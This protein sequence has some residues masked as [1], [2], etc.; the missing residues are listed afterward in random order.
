MY[1]NS[2]DGGASRR[3]LAVILAGVMA[4]ALA[5][6]AEAR[7][8]GK[9]SFGSR[10]SRTFEAPP[11]TRTAPA[12]A[13][14]MQRSQTTPSQAQ[15][16]PTAAA[17]QAAQPA[18]SRFGGGFFAGLLGAGLLGA[19]FGAG[20]FGGLGSLAS[21]V[22]FVLQLGLIGGLAYLA[23]QFFRRRQQPAMAGAGANGP[24]QRTALGGLAAQNGATHSGAGASALGGAATA[25]SAHRQA[26][27]VEIEPDDYAA[28]ERSLH[29]I[30]MAYGREDVAALWSLATPEMAGYLQEELNENARR[31]VLNTISGVRLV[32]GDLAEAWRE[33]TTDYAT[34]AMRFELAEQMVDRATRQPAASDIGKPEPVTEV[35]TFRREAGGDW[36]LSAIQQVA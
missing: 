33:G 23:V 35:W 7:P 34:V 15:A 5:G 6:V 24:M 31:G 4:L 30:H 9:G 8:G 25:T 27:T 12:T 36:K 32:Q 21:I 14:P 16:G 29:D 1:M 18:K 19:L 10:G 28:F 20:L 3:I 2:F 26:M 13:Q 11:T 22:G 17:A